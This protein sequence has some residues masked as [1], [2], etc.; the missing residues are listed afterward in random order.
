VDVSEPILE[1]SGI[2]AGYGRIQVLRDVDLQVPRGAV[3]ALLGPNGAGKS[4]TL[5]VASGQLQPTAGCV[6]LAG[7][8]VNGASPD[9]LARQGLCTIPEGR[10]VFPNL[11]VR[12]NLRL[13]AYA[14]QRSEAEIEEV[15]YDRFPRLADR[16]ALLAGRLSGGEQ[17]MLTMARALASD[18]AVLLLDELSMGLAP[19][20]VA[21]LY[22]V[23]G[24]LAADGLSVLVVEQFAR[25]ALAIADYAVVMVNGRVTAVGEPQDVE[26]QISAAYLGGAA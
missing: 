20:I 15:A 22:D 9:V 25:T 19:L 10:S 1:L 4:T 11:T 13:S 23:V 7:V 12:E 18:P 3:V 5:K 6:H 16:R 8:H 21:E 17:Q 26:D 24:Q 2:D 14:A